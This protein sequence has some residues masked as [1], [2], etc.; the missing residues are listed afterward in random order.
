M[1][2]AEVIV[3]EIAADVEEI[4]VEIVEDAVVSAGIGEVNK[5]MNAARFQSESGIFQ[6]QK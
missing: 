3:V 6:N 1:I 4:A 5:Y 2:A